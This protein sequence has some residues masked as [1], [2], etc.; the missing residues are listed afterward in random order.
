MDCTRTR[1]DP[2]AAVVARIVGCHFVA[3]WCSVAGNDEGCGGDVLPSP[4]TR[5]AELC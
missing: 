1:K 4:L 3:V 5:F 2:A